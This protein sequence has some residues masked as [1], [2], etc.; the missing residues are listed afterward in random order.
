VLTG[1]S[2]ELVDRVAALGLAGDRGHDIP[3]G[4]DVSTFRPGDDGRTAWRSRLGIPA[5]ATVVLAVGRM[6]TKKG[7]QVLLPEL[8]RL[9]ERHPSC[10]VVLAGGGDR[11]EEFR[12]TV[13][14]LAARVHLPGVIYHD[15]L[16]GLYRAADV[17]VMPAVHDG[18]GNV[19]GLPNVILEA[20]ASGLPVVASGISGI[21]L[22]VADGMNGI[23]VPEGD[24]AAVH[25]ALD[26]LLRRPDEAKA[27][28][29]A[30]RRKA[31]ADLTWDAVAGRYRMAYRAALA[32]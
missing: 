21:P 20:M 13:A 24:G 12:R 3:N 28:G 23:L 18:A 7:F 16:P 30:G 17:F 8:R 31:A 14:Q 32:R 11:L 2:P 27:M 15:A 6:A 9:L 25:A 22:A 4:V 5:S 1:C 29:A 19:D 10:H 26:R